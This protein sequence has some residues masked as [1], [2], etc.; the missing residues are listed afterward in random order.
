MHA[1]ILLTYPALSLAMARDGSSGGCIRMCVITKDKVERHFVPGDQLPR[2][3][4]GKEVVGHAAG[5]KTA[6]AA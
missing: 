4:E 1:S 5:V 6:I 2:F 3:W